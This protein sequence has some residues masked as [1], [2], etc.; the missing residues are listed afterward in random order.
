MP[1]LQNSPELP[2]TRASVRGRVT[3]RKQKKTP[4]KTANISPI[5]TATDSVSAQNP[6]VD[7]E[8]KK[9]NIA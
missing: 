8:I 7:T 5:A 3:G 2:P 4:N 9:R 1:R 6:N